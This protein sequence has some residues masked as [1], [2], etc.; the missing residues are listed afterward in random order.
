MRRK[1]VFT[2][3]FLLSL[4][5]AVAGQ[6]QFSYSK[7]IVSGS[8]LYLFAIILFFINHWFYKKETDIYQDFADKTLIV[9]EV[10]IG[11]DLKSW[12][13][14]FLLFSFFLFAYV[15]FE[16]YKETATTFDFFVW[17]ASLILFLISFV[18][19]KGFSFRSFRIYITKNHFEIIAVGLITIGALSLRLY[20]LGVIPLGV[21]QEEGFAGMGALDV[22]EG[23]LSNPFGFGP[24]SAWGLTY[25][26]A[27]Y[28]Y[29]QALF[30]ELFDVNLFSLRFFSAIAGALA[31]VFTYLLAREIWGRGV[32]LISGIL[33][34]VAGIHI[35]F[36]RFGFPLIQTSL[37]ATI[38][39][40]FLVRAVRNRTP[41]DFAIAGFGIGLAQHF[42]TASRILPFIALIF[43][44]F[45]IFQERGFLTRYY[46]GLII[47]FVGFLLTFMPIILPI[48]K[49][50]NFTEGPS[51]DF[52]FG[53]W[54]ASDYISRLNSGE[55]HVHILGEQIVRSFLSF[56][57]YPDKSYL[58]GG[59][60]GGING[61][62]L[63]F[64]TSILFI[65][66]LS[67][68]VF[69]WKKSAYLLLLIAFFGS[70]FSL[71]ALTI[72]PPNYQR[73]VVI[74]SLPF[75]FS[76]VGIWKFYEYL[77]EIVRSRKLLYITLIC[78]LL[79]LGWR[80]YERY[81]SE[82]KKSNYWALHRDP[83][84]QIAHFVESLDT[85]YTVYIPSPYMHVPWT[86]KFILEDAPYKIDYRKLPE[87]LRDLE[88]NNISKAV[89]IVLPEHSKSLGLLRQRFPGGITS[90]LSDDFQYVKIYKIN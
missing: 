80:N 22:I 24:V 15:L 49:F 78:L 77:G 83:A 44:L 30:I 18:D 41:V 16:A 11:L 26:P 76:A 45:K 60:W 40:F 64:F 27:L 58:Y 70:V 87:V 67:Y 10:A 7:A 56:N 36:S 53:G 71:V 75:I 1:I 8:I 86:L 9:P 20:K 33:V 72:D 74:L 34:A 43:F 4:V 6:Y 32:G 59:V 14:W 90:S 61:P 65:L 82:Y 38:S 68:I 35:H 88:T 81:F 28:F 2:A 85:S 47:L 66:G 37:F 89:F 29:G 62:M 79:I 84:T 69:N 51:R 13:S 17:T 54:M 23:R 39:L 48:E 55:S 25:Y 73:I 63:E 46:K 52:I 21:N 42:W 5:F 50:R 3:S 31:V 57:F 12:R 19:L